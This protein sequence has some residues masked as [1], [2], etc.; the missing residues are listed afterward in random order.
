MVGS[1]KRIEN[2][3]IIVKR[4]IEEVKT[5]REENRKE[6]EEIRRQGKAI[7]E[8]IERGKRERMELKE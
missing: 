3:E 8:R 4:L 7:E 5:M 6:R 2:L 1:S